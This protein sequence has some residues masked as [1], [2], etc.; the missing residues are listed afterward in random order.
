MEATRVRGGA[1][2]CESERDDIV[3][4]G[5]TESRRRETNERKGPGGELSK[6]ILNTYRV[7]RLV[8]P[9]MLSGMVPVRLLYQRFLQQWDGGDESEG[10]NGDRRERERRYREGGSDGIEK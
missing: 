4:E 6:P 2:M 1:V 10:P 3:R 5:A 9:L 8:M 7:S